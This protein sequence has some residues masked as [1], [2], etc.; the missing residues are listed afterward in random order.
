MSRREKR[1]R[2]ALQNPRQVRFETLVSI[3]EDHGYVGRGGTG[4]H[5]VLRNPQTGATVTLSRPHGGRKHM[6]IVAVRDALRQI[7]AIDDPL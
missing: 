6:P 1:L 7:G 2:D 5:V 4:S 3:L